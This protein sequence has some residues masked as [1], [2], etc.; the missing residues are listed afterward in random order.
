MEDKIKECVK[1]VKGTEDISLEDLIQDYLDYLEEK[2]K[3]M[4]PKQAA[5]VLISKFN[6]EL[7]HDY[8]SSELVGFKVRVGDVCYAD[9][10][11]AYINEAGFQHFCIVIG[12]H[13]S[14]AVVLPMS[15]N[16]TMYQQSYCPKTFPNGKRHLY[17]LP[18][19]LSL[20]SKRSVLFLNDLKCINTAR[21]IE[22]KGNIGP[23]SLLFNDIL[24]RS[25]TLL[26][27]N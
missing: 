21:I 8:K 16:F 22:V 23:N 19:S 15:S 17:R 1:I 7:R 13:N 11:E 26:H 18:E 10:G 24:E 2:L 6:Y 3:N 20:L 25:K 14:K 12:Y 9:F 4:H 5:K 27:H